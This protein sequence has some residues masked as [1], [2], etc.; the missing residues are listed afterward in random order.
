MPSAEEIKKLKVAKV[1]CES[2]LL[3]FT[4]YFFKAQTGQKFICAGLHAQIVAALMS[5]VR[6]E[7]KNLIINVPPRY[8][9]TELAVIKFIA[10]CIA[11][12]PAAKFIHLS[13]SDDLALDNSGKVKELV[14]SEEYQI[15]WPVRLKQDSKSKKKWYTEAGGGLYATAAGGP[16][17]GFGA[18]STV[19]GDGLFHGA[20]IIDDPHKVDDIYSDIERA[21]VTHRL[22]TTIK[23]RRNSRHTP[24]V[25]IMQ[26][27]HE[28]DMAGFALAG[29]MGEEF[30]LLKL[31][32]LNPDGTALWDFKHTAGE[33]RQMQLTDP[34][35]FS[36]QYQQ[37]P[38]PEDGEFFKR[39][40]VKWYD[41]PSM[42][43]HMR[44]YGASDY[45]V[46]ADGG[47]F[48]VHLVVGVDP[49]D[50]IYIVD[51]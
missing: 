36:G 20:I 38:S 18:G 50:D 22:N 45:A 37:E 31:Q 27:L 21:K 29:G 32:A 8:G 12:N 48:T 11:L 34:Y 47:D 15:F 30:H 26:R 7:I 6:G 4:R 51:L 14:E 40:W 43:K 13:Y 16:L 42:P 3:F 2:D 49:N 25:I 41:L 44:F 19:E 5:V 33:L 46:T 28:E 23:S 10:W 9:K 39:A 35:G 24:I 17:T 1:W